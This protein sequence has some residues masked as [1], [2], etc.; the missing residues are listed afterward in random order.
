[1]MG[2]QQF[3]IG[4]QE[5]EE[6]VMCATLLFFKIMFDSPNVISTCRPGYMSNC[7]WYYYIIYMFKFIY[8]LF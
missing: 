6:E 3:I 5:E 4:W 8:L 2:S 1:M 7:V